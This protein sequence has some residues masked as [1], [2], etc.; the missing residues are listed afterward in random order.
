MKAT[1]SLALT[2]PLLSLPA[3]ADL[4]PN[5]DFEN[6]SAFW[7]DGEVS[8]GADPYSFSYPTNGGNDDGYGIIDATAADDT[9]SFGIWV[10]NGDD[11]L[12]LDSLG[13]SAGSTYLFSQD[14]IILSGENLGRFKIDF[15]NGT[16][17]VSTT[18]KL[19]AELLG[20]GTTWETYEYEIQIPEGVDQ[21]KVVPESGIS[22]SVGFDNIGFDPTPILPPVEPPVVE[23]SEAATLTT[24]TLVSWSPTDAEKFYQPQSSEDGTTWTNLGPAFLGVETTT[25]LDPNSSSF[26]RVQ[27]KEPAGQQ[28]IVNGD[29]EVASAGDPDC[30]ESWSCLSA[31]GQFPAR[32]VTDAFSG[33]S[34]IRIAVQNDDAGAPNQAEIQQ[35]LLNV[36]GFVTPGETYTFS[37]WAKQISSGVSYVQ[38]YSLQWTDGAGAVIN[39][40][41][42][43]FTSFNGGDGSWS[44]ISVP[45][46][47]APA[48]AAGVFIQIF[49]ATGAVPGADAK[50]EVLIDAISLSLGG[51]AAPVN[52][53]ATTEPGIGIT[54]RTQTGI[55][56][57]A[58]QSEDLENFEDLTGTFTGNGQ[59]VGAGIPDGGTSHFFRFLKITVE[60][61]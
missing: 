51:G 40:A 42:I 17:F 43:N 58:Q 12:T 36:G 57:K 50:G 1:Y 45:N 21:I 23:P 19:S 33:S 35:N 4:F 41:G 3:A 34:S 13:L 15:F 46:L 7:A 28:A 37:F 2:L 44:E 61:N 30:P 32:I 38:N 27:E 24:G 14:M 39:G 9:T 8:G 52:L 6:G 54:Q 48:S 16:S 26:Y 5:G 59:A 47:V 55:L 31:S 49:G 22:S 18:N 25:I 53:E 10:A 11:F 56:Y 20:D 60:E 29:F